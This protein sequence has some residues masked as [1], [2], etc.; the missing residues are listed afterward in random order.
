MFQFLFNH[1]DG[2]SKAMIIDLDAHQVRQHCE[3]G[4]GGIPI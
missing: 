1:V 3:R 2:V 4:P